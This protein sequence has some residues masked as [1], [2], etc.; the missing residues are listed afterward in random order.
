MPLV[1]GAKATRLIREFEVM[2]SPRIAQRAASY[3]RVPIIAVS[4]SLSEQ[5]K[6]EYVDIGFDG[7]I[8]KPIDFKRL[9]TILSAMQDE[10]LRE[11]LLYSRGSWETG[12]WFNT[13]T[14]VP[15]V[16][17]PYSGIFDWPVPIREMTRNVA[18]NEE[19]LQ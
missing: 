11:Q 9:E 18:S 7:W 4:A 16:P 13:K 5:R 2:S 6:D 12:G 1:D 15:K 10:E 17:S 3:G 19:S 14:H 8:L